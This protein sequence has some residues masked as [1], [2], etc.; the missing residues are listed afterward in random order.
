MAAA[1][2]SFIG[3]NSMTYDLAEPSSELETR[4]DAYAARVV[5]FPATGHKRVETAAYARDMALQLAV[6]LREIEANTAACLLDA[7]AKELDSLVM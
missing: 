7:A 6:L 5:R 4:H 2:R 1:V 3:G